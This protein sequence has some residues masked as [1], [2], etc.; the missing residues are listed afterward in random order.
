MAGSK[1]YCIS[2]VA[3][4]STRARTIVINQSD[5]TEKTIQKGMSFS[6][7][8]NFHI[9]SFLKSVLWPKRWQILSL[10]W[11]NVLMI[12]RI[13]SGAN[14]ATW[15][16]NKQYALQ[17]L[18]YCPIYCRQSNDKSWENMVIMSVPSRTLCP[19]GWKWGYLFF[20]RKSME[21]KKFPWQQ[22]QFGWI[23]LLPS[24]KNTAS[25]FP[26]IF[27]I[28]YF[29]NLVVHLMTSSLSWFFSI[30]KDLSSTG[31]YFSCHMHLKKESLKKYRF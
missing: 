17:K 19:T 25:I 30:L 26:E 6:L 31:K 5:V 7:Q 3:D 29:T 11:H 14:D 8:L 1:S 22:Q 24:L 10:T 4:W 18:C 23:F 13:H 9:L 21:P 28:Q 12:I 27:F 20:D 2:P 16:A 15:A